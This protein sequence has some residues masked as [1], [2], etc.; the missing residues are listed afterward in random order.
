MRISDKIF[1]TVGIFR[2]FCASTVVQSIDIRPMDGAVRVRVDEV[3]R[4]EIR[5]HVSYAETTINTVETM[6]CI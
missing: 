1:L 2:W 6:L 4:R 5:N 3:L